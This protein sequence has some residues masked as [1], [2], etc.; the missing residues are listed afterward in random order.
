MTLDLINPRWGSWCADIVLATAATLPTGRSSLV[1]G[2][3]SLVGSVFR[4]ASFSGAR[5]ARIVGGAG[6][7]DN[8]IPAQD[9]VGSSVL[10]ST[11]LRDAATLVGETIKMDVADTN[12][13]RFTREA[14]PAA[15][16]LRQVAGNS[17]WISEDGITHIGPIPTKQVKQPFQVIM[18]SGKTGKFEVATEALAEWIPGNTFV[19]PGDGVQT[20]QSVSIKSTNDGKLRVSVLADG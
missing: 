20:I 6:G 12:L 13:R 1:V 8:T 15:R 18:W 4:T 17:W 10:M 5:S 3:M 2:D 7:W 16:V 11:V 14:G 19:G 9:Y